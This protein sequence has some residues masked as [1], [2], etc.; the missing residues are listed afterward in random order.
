MLRNDPRGELIISQTLTPYA[1][2]ES[3]KQFASASITYTRLLTPSP[4]PGLASLATLTPRT[5]RSSP[6]PFAAERAKFSFSLFRL[7]KRS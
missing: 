3:A 2:E 5:F 4:K 6:G 1:V 7:Y